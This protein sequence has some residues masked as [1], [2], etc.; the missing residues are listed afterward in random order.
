MSNILQPAA[1]PNPVPTANP[2]QGGQR[3]YVQTVPLMR[4]VAGSANYSAL[5]SPFRIWHPSVRL[6][7]AATIGFRPDAAEDAAIPAGFVATL[8]AWAK[9]DR[10]LGGFPIRGNGIIPGPF[11]LSTALPWTYEAVT[12]VD[13]WRGIMTAPAGGTGLAVTGTFYLTVTWEPVGG[14]SSVPDAELQRLFDSCKVVP[15]NFPTV[16]QSVGG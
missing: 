14:A 6:H 9:T 8:D 12:G 11:A 4:N 5:T 3:R 10:Q 16:F 1:Q 13:E 7:G 15:G 2:L